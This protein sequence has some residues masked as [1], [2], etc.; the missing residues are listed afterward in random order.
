MKT[1]SLRR[2]FWSLV[3]IS[4]ALVGLRMATRVESSQEPAP[5]RDRT[6]VRKPWSLEPVK[7][8][9][10]KN[11]RKAK[12]EI[13]KPFDDDDDW[14]DGF[15]VTVMNDYDKTVT[16]MTVSMVFRRDL[17][18]TRPPFA[19]NLHFGPRSN[20]PEYNYRDLNKV[21][22]VGKTVDLQLNADDYKLLKRGLEQ[23]GYPNSIQRVEV[24]IREVG[25]EDGSMLYSGTFYLQDPA[26]P[27]DPTKKIRVRQP[28]GG[29]KQEIRIPTNQSN[30]M[31]GVSFRRASLTTTNSTRFSL[32]FPGAMQ[33]EDCM[34]QDE[35]GERN[36]QGSLYCS[37]EYDRLSPFEEGIYEL[38]STIE[39]CEQLI[40]TQWY[41]CPNFSQ[42]VERFSECCHFEYCGDPSAEPNN[43]CSGCPEDYDLV[44][45]CCY[46][47]TGG[48]GKCNY[49]YA[50]A[51]NCQQMGG[52]YNPDV[53]SC[54][55]ET[56]IVIDVAG[57]GFDLT[58]AAGG[59]NFDL[60]NDG[61]KERLSWT[62]AGSGDAWLV[63]DRNGNGTIDNGK[64]VFG[65][66][67][68]QGPAPAG[69]TRNGFLALALYDKTWNG[70]NGDGVIDSRDGIFSSL[71]LWQDTN[72][73]GISEPWELHAL[74][75]LGVESISLDYK[76]SRRT[77]RYGNTFR[78][79]AKVYGT[80]HRDLGRWA[81]DVLLVH[82]P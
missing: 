20:S 25:F 18:D 64:E 14:L 4:L 12:I 81:Y 28:P 56:P 72:H 21:I 5:Q 22:R 13:G 41:R 65:N 2:I 57:N 80:N 55:P 9:A 33:S 7:V 16:A 60:N 6:V 17:G 10:A 39:Y 31:T 67:T 11:K 46:P 23:T 44:G 47:S 61:T 58:D 29:K 74:P 77:D 59:V 32:T 62:A 63:L 45:S 49:D 53:C 43:S 30:S 70:G 37:Q 71:R 66:T 3:Y 40:G 78:Y 27:N 82:G 51:Y 52:F 36:C 75:E 69:A 26:Y 48:R 54:D 76:E 38:G 35:S 24:V 19:W 8:V 50:N 15:S 1:K 68:P 34:A 42:E 73:N 79:R